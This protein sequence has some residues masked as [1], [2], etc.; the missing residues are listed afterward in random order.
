M[1]KKLNSI[2]ANQLYEEECSM[3]LDYGYLKMEMSQY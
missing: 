1:L 2:C 3:D